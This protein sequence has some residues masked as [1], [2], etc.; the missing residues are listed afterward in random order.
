MKQVLKRVIIIIACAA[1]FLGG[2]CGT[3]HDSVRESIEK[4][5]KGRYIDGIPEI[6]DRGGGWAA[7][8]LESL[9]KFHGRDIS[10]D[11][12]SRRIY[13]PKTERANIPLIAHEVEMD[14]MEAVRTTSVGINDY[15]GLGLPLLMPSHIAA[16]IQG[17]PPWIIIMGYDDVMEVMI[18]ETGKEKAIISYGDF[19]RL[20]ALNNDELLVVSPPGRM[21]AVVYSNEAKR[22]GHR[23]DYFEAIRLFE[24]AVARE[25]GNA[26]RA[27]C[28]IRICR[29]YNG[30]G[31]LKP[32]IAACN[33]AIEIQP[34]EGG[35]WHELAVTIY[36]DSGN[37]AEVKPLLESAIAV[38]PEKK[39]YYHAEL[40]RMYFESGNL[41][42]A[43]AQYE[44]ALRA[45]IPKNAQPDYEA[46]LLIRT[47]EV[48]EAQGYPHLGR[49]Y[50]E[51]AF[52]K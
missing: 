25:S 21:P 11:V 19:E 33:N 38:S 49:S 6:V 24:L 12:I 14:G 32:A 42:A 51:K 30:L 16:G 3:L 5:G 41:P 4:H 9:F 35:N 48:I 34:E 15:L 47:A 20:A 27:D 46:N 23:A 10:Q 40:G 17:L 44:E 7:A 37:I 13:N 28:Y 26:F 52:R 22:A 1:G 29:A 8:A 39:S 2:G 43:R 31:Y 18:C 50:R 45:E 36:S